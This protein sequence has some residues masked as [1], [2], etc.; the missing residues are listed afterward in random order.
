M[1]RY[2]NVLP[3]LLLFVLPALAQTPATPP[4]GF[5]PITVYKPNWET[6]EESLVTFT[7]ARNAQDIAL[8]YQCVAW[9][10]PAEGEEILGGSRVAVRPIE[11]TS[12]LCDLLEKQYTDA[13]TA[14]LIARLRLQTYGVRG[15]LDKMVSAPRTPSR[16]RTRSFAMSG[17]LRRG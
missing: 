16:L 3:L 17:R 15:M 6:P 10:S 1:S 11:T 13:G 4:P 7:R 2:L 9:K 14:E 12:E 5:P 8:L